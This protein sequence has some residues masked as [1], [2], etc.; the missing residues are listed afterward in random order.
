MIA[1]GPD[2]QYKN[3]F[4]GLAATS[5]ENGSI[6]KLE[7]GDFSFV[8][9]LKSVVFYAKRCGLLNGTLGFR[10]V[11]NWTGDADFAK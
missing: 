9:L 6:I 3:R 4:H 8:G 2:P 7:R 11:A 5:A 10:V 1:I